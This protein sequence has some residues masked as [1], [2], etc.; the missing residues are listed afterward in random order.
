MKTRLSVLALL[1]ALGV[2]GMPGC[3]QPSMTEADPAAFFEKQRRACAVVVARLD[4]DEVLA[5]TFTVRHRRSDGA[6]RE[7]VVLFMRETAA[8]SVAR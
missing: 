8:W 1:L 4:E 2:V 3:S 5:Q 6:E 7:A